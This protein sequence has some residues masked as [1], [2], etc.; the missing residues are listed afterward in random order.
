MT[1]TDDSETNAFAV[2]EL[3]EL[4]DAAE[5]KALQGNQTFKD[6]KD[7]A[8]SIPLQKKDV[9]VGVAKAAPG[10]GDAKICVS[11]KAE[12]MV[13]KQKA[14]AAASVNDAKT[15]GSP[16]AELLDD[17]QKAEGFE[18]KLGL[19]EDMLPTAGMS[20]SPSANGNEKKAAT[21]HVAIDINENAAEPSV[22]DVSPSAGRAQP[23]PPRPGAF[24]A[25]FGTTELQRNET[26]HADM[27]Q[28]AERSIP[29]LD[30]R[31]SFDDGANSS[32][33]V[34]DTNEGLAVANEVADEQ[35]PD[36]PRA[37]EETGSPKVA[38]TDEN[39]SR[40]PM[41][42]GLGVAIVAGIVLL[43]VFTLAG[44]GEQDKAGSSSQPT[45][46]QQTTP[47]P[48]QAPTSIE[49]LVLAH[50]PQE[51]IKAIED[52]RSPQARAYE[53][54]L[55]DPSLSDY[56]GTRII[57]RF[58]L[59]TLYYATNG[60]KWRDNKLWMNHAYHECQWYS[61]MDENPGSGTQDEFWDDWATQIFGGNYQYLEP[62]LSCEGSGE[63]VFTH[64]WLFNNN[65]DGQLPPEFYLLTNLKTVFLDGNKLDGTKIQTEIGLL[66][67]LE[68][69]LSWTVGLVGTVPTEVGL[70]TSMQDFG[71]SSNSLTGTVPTEFGLL[72][73][74]MRWFG[75]DHNLLTSTL[76]T[77]IGRLSL[78]QW[79]M[80]W[81]NDFT[82]TMPTELCQITDMD[83]M[84]LELNQLS[85][86]IPSC[87]GEL[88]KLTS[89]WLHENLLTGP[90]PT[91]MGLLT[92]LDAW[93]IS[94]QHISGTIPTEI[95][96]DAIRLL[97]LDGNDLTGP[98]PTEVG[99]APTLQHLHVREN[100]LSGPIP[101]EIGLAS[102]LVLLVVDDNQLTGTIPRE[103]DFL[104]SEGNFS[105]LFVSGNNFSGEL[106]DEMCHLG[107]N[108]TMGICPFKPWWW[109]EEI[110]CG[111]YFDCTEDFYGC[112]C[113]ADGVASDNRTATAVSGE[114]ST[115]T[116]GGG[117]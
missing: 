27:L 4:L 111:L 81:H 104:A 3:A 38:P 80:F 77:E 48:T 26:F 72:S 99:L 14:K 29:P 67:N 70:L 21:D 114:N 66:S 54:L 7:T 86:S 41:Y 60:D 97:H 10:V 94:G 44:K 89:I 19:V 106:S 8:K 65:L 110:E 64:L 18:R 57:Q 20:P 36:L 107:T 15:S 12:L 79:F 68:L 62:F 92:L 75:M 52:N 5:A 100:A 95:F 108:D 31:E 91:E 9:H 51:T 109:S 43:L 1:T 71:I 103:L 30:T 56:S 32:P 116:A 28:G 76:P 84:V 42:W 88:T 93:Q 87:I 98:L 24:A 82:G 83:D 35:P 105:G 23:P 101:S 49:E 55:A 74:T 117:Q 47:F 17:K 115:R 25:S 33:I 2:T 6:T 50:L 85:G 90:I 46:Q 39:D 58:S 69:L 113:G 22:S 78:V 16:K 34:T 45:P 61:R 73:D 53:W 11:P 59:A 63:Q 37:R 96:N 40:M 13:A 102:S 112:G